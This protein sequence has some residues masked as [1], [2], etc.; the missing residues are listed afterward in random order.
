[1]E[2]LGAVASAI[3]LAALFKHAVEAFEIID[4]YHNQDDDFKTLQLQ[5]QMEQ[6]RLYVWGENMG[7][8]DSSRP[9][10][11]EGWRFEYLVVQLLHHIVRLF[12]DAY[13]IRERYGCQNV[14]G[15]LAARPARTSRTIRAEFN[16]FKIR[17]GRAEIAQADVFRKTRWAIRD[18]KKFT[19]LIREV[20]C[21]IT[22][23][24]DVTR[25]LSNTA[26]QGQSIRTR[27][28]PIE[29]TDTLN[30]TTRACET[31]HP[32]IAAAAS[33]QADYISMSSGRL[34]DISDWQA[35]IP[36]DEYQDMSLGSLENLTI[37]ELKHSI[38]QLMQDQATQSRQ[39]SVLTT[40]LDRPRSATQTTVIL[41]FNAGS[42]KLSTIAFIIC[43]PM[44]FLAGFSFGR[45][46][47]G[48]LTEPAI[49]TSILRSSTITPRQGTDGP[50]SVRPLVSPPAVS[51]IVRR[52]LQS[53]FHGS[54]GYPCFHAPSPK[55][56]SP[57]TGFFKGPETGLTYLLDLG[58]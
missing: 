41:G 55:R 17:T 11:L 28:R 54:A 45:M 57:Q 3:T 20:R 32:G 31:S 23:L 43:L 34:R 22:N 49:A 50:A 10:L 30:E 1:M 47:V 4:L 29:D 39:I 46:S 12:N 27:I 40:A 21:L 26:R 53:V 2:I 35:H 25:E 48:C 24:E 9:N 8:T 56:A 42:L 52:Q 58:T 37:T 16:N 33:F 38:I 13:V 5:L 51:P 15:E 18:R 14:A 7:L 19:L 44:I 6:C 36:T